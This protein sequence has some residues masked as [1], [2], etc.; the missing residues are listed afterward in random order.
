MWPLA[1]AKHQSSL[2]AIKFTLNPKSPI[3]T[4]NSQLHG[5]SEGVPTDSDQVY[6]TSNASA[7]CYFYEPWSK[8]YAKAKAACAA[9]GGYLVA[10][11]SAQEQLQVWP[12]HVLPPACTIMS[13]EQVQSNG[14]CCA[15][16]TVLPW[17]R[18]APAA[19]GHYATV[20]PM[21]GTKA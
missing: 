3:S 21:S 19:G 1:T 20:S 8:T 14:Q 11:N 6:C 16:G 17:H 10:Y 7:S 4:T 12:G 9:K 5:P 15:G 13:M 2:L 18:V